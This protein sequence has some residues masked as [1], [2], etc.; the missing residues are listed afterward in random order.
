M[1]LNNRFSGI[2]QG[3][4]VS[5]GNTL[6]IRTG[7]A[8]P[9]AANDYVNGS[10]ISIN[11][12]LVAAAGFPNGTTFSGS[13]SSASAILNIP[14][15]STIVFAQLF[16]VST[17]PANPN[18]SITFRTPL[19][20]NTIA[21]NT[22]LNQTSGTNVWVT[23][24]VTNIVNT[25]KSGFYTVLT[26]PGANITNGSSVNGAS[27]N[28]IVIYKNTALP[29]RYF[30]VNSGFSD[31][32]SGA[33]SDFTFS[34]IVTPSSGT[35]KGYLLIT[36]NF[37]DLLDGAQIFVGTSLAT[38]VKVGNTS[39]T[40]WNGIAPYAQINNMLPGNILIADTNDPNIG[41]LDT[42][43]TFGA[44]NKNPFN[45]TAPA[46]ARNMTDILGLD[47]S[48]N[49]T[50]NQTSLFTRVTY[51][52]SGAGTLTS[53]SVQVD[54]NSA[55]I[56][57][58]KT[59]DKGISDIGDTLTYT[60]VLKN[61]GL[62]NANSVYFIDTVPTVT[63]FISGTFSVNGII[64]PSANIASPGVNLTTI[65][66]N[67]VVTVSFKVT[68]TATIPTPNPLNNTSQTTFNFLP[69][70]GLAPV[71]TDA[72]SNTVQT[73]IVN[74]VLTSY[75]TATPQVGI[76]DTITYT[77]PISNIGNTT[78]TNI[79]FIDTLP[80]TVSFVPGSLNQDGTGLSG[81]PNPPGVSLNNILSGTTS[82][83]SFKVTVLT[84]PTPNIINNSATSTYNYEVTGGTPSLGSGG[85]STNISRTTVNY[86]TLN[87]T[88]YVSKSYANIGDTLNYTIVLQNTGIVTAINIIFIDTVPNNT[89]IIP[90]TFKQDGIILPG[91]PDPPGV[92]LPTSIAPNKTTTI[93]FSVIINTMPNP[94]PIPNMASES[95]QY[96]G[97]PEI[98]TIK[99]NSSSGNTVTTQVNNASLNG[100][101]KLVDKNFANCG[102]TITYTLLV[103]NSGNVTAQNVVFKDTIPKGTVFVTNSVFVNGILQSGAT[104]A[105]GVPI[106]NIGPGATATL[107]FSV[108][109]QC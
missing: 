25:S 75:K 26:N 63:K 56:S 86:A 71:F 99:T 88:K 2:F 14:S 85:V 23:Q 91:L 87:A 74:A 33:P 102:D 90:S 69:G 109:V 66:S 10:Y 97:N 6:Q 84:I 82:T 47:I 105:I 89:T 45:S 94:N 96:I 49:L 51:I 73:T 34:N 22:T 79:L 58:V 50:N 11:T 65:A 40:T 80:S 107:T 95:F 92:T 61:A 8:Y 72:T 98:P 60:V 104:P 93:T 15:G 52:G 1:P 19:G 39:T 46:F 5:T 70:T 42:R 32:S 103:P 77:I 9:P 106:P 27:W 35:V 18:A 3:A 30:S 68:V 59:V 21:P 13:Q 29:Y 16:W 20:D 53:Q 108:I 55:N 100:I 76:F 7:T 54:V 101:T 57:L 12:A 83:V 44:F 31:V 36:E 38:S 67:G 17:S 78:A 62:S 4:M 28:L 24:D 43:G 48:N 81:N 37:G 64:V 41:L